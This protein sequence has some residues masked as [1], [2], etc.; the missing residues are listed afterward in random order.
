MREISYLEAVREAMSQE[1]R[2][3]QDVFILGEDIGVY[4]G[5][6]GVTRGMIE[7]FGP[8]RVRNTPISE[9]AIAGGAVGAALTGMRPILELQF[10]DFITIAMDQLV[11]Q[12]AKTRYMFGGKGKVPL[13]VRT[14]AGS[15]TGAAAQHSQ[16]LEAWMAHIPGLK[17][18][19]PS[20][21]YDAK[22]LLKAAMDDDNPVIFYEHK[23]L[24]KT[25]G[26][27]PEEQY[28]IPLGK[29]DVKRS[30]KDVTI[31]ATAIMVHKALEAAKELE[32]EGIDVEIIDPRTLVPLDEET[33][34]ESVKKTGKC[35]VIHEAVKRGG[36]GGEIASMIAES[37]AFDY[38]D[39]P[40]KRLGGLAVPIP[41][42]P[43]LEKAVIPQVP[44]IIEAAKELVRS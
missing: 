26:E 33:I 18:V 6:F 7:E 37:E 17:V 22:G 41:Y 9:A 8:E 3:N 29:A 25:I 30:G 21:A 32:A 35:I 13:V 34:I 28:S 4:G 43:T 38:L 12:A 39:A 19:Q 20:T 1:M 31:V 16:S 27:V 2:E 14:P 11:N 15:G 24:Y 5:A 42:N 10:S 40:I 23:L 44:D 36:Y